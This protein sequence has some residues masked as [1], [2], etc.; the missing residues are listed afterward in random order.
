M[1]KYVRCVLLSVLLSPLAWAAPLVIR[2]VTVIDATGKPAQHGMTVVIE[3]D[4][5]VAIGPWTREVSDPRP[6]GHARAWLASGAWQRGGGRDVDV[7][8]A[9]GQRCRRR[10]CDGGA[11]ER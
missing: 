9:S 7:S 6:L 11:G 5:I 10:A 2:R 8:A 1:Q 3:Q 4:Q